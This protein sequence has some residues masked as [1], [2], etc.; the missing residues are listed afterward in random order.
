M[1]VRIFH[2]A[3]FRALVSEAAVGARCF[4]HA[5]RYWKPLHQGRR[6]AVYGAAPDY[7][8]SLQDRVEDYEFS[9]YQSLLR[10]HCGRDGLLRPHTCLWQRD[11]CY[12]ASIGAD[13]DLS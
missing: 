10:D 12:R 4:R 5:G 8:A 3:A 11:G 2:K 7:L 6:F 13:G 9:F 1:R